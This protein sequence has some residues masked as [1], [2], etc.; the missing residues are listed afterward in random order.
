MSGS[1]TG[2]ALDPDSV[3][4][5][6]GRRDEVVRLDASSGQL[7]D[8]IALGDAGCD[9]PRGIAV[10]AGG[11]WVGCYGSGVVV[12]ID[13]GDGSSRS[14]PRRRREPGRR[15]GRWRWQR[16]GHRAHAVG[17]LSPRS[18]MSP[19][20][21]IE[22]HRDT[23]H[24]RIVTGS[25][26][27]SAVGR[28]S[29]PE[30]LWM[31]PSTGGRLRWST[32]SHWS[33]A[34]DETACRHDHRTP[35]SLIRVHRWGDRDVR[36]TR[37]GSGVSGGRHAPGGKRAPLVRPT[38][39]VLGSRLGGLAGCLLRMLFTY[40]GRPTEEGGGFSGPIWP[41]AWVPHRRMV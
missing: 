40:N 19:S 35:P 11:V 8:P 22:A 1:P 15:R 33:R 32:R 29:S 39:L 31:N 13:P 38:E 23:D 37:P 20:T 6:I 28:E 7:R 36:S 9:G 30:V 18:R 3:W 2:I 12:L 10:G 16:L 14:D 17:S 41:P 26:D 5:S 4:I 34:T 21:R 27:L 25:I 24:S